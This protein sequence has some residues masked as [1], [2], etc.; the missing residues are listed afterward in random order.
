MR[1][2]LAAASPPTSDQPNSPAVCNVTPL[3]AEG[4]NPSRAALKSSDVI[5]RQ[6]LPVNIK[7]KNITGSKTTL[8]L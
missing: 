7:I 3:N 4:M 2:P 6:E 5:V 8:F 1:V